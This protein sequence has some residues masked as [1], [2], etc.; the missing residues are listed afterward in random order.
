MCG[1]NNRIVVEIKCLKKIS[2]GCAS[3]VFNG[4]GNGQFFNR[5]RKMV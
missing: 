3:G 5:F 1:F 2:G 4:R